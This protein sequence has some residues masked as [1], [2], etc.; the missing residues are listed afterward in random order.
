MMRS[1]I[2]AKR[3]AVVFVCLI[4]SACGSPAK[5]KN[6]IIEATPI[7]TQSVVIPTPAPLSCTATASSAV[8]SVFGDASGN[9]LPNL[10]SPPV[11]VTVAS[12]RAG[13]PVT[14]LIVRIET[15]SSDFRVEPDSNVSA[16]QIV[17]RP[18]KKGNH[19]A[20]I[21][22]ATADNLSE[23]AKCSF[24]VELR[25][26][27]PPDLRVMIAANGAGPSITL[28][29][30]QGAVINWAAANATACLLTRDGV[31]LPNQPIVGVLSGE[32]QVGPFAN[33]GT[34]PLSTVYGIECQGPAGTG[35]LQRA[36]VGVTVNPLPR[37]ELDIVGAGASKTI[38]QGESVDLVWSSV[39][40]TN[41]CLLS[42]GI[43]SEFVPASGQMRMENIPSSVQYAIYCRDNFRGL[44]SD[45][46]NVAAI[47]PRV[48]IT[49][50][51]IGGSYSQ[52]IRE[53]FTIGWT[54]VDVT[55]CSVSPLNDNRIVG[56]VLV[57]AMG[58][59]RTTIYMV[60]C[61]SYFG[62]VISSVTVNYLGDWYQTSK[63]D[64]GNQ[65]DCNNFCGTFG[66]ANVNSPDGSRCAS[67]ELI[68]PSALGKIN[69]SKGCGDYS[70]NTAHGAPNGRS[71]GFAANAYCW[72]TGQKTNKNNSD[73]VMGCFC[74]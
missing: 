54:G 48:V 22:V 2:N 34:I 37:A 33:A 68:P 26:T 51:G 15:S 63:S 23:V 65:K 36:S 40:A 14:A 30:G 52:G 20:T 71:E 47:N 66:K 9:L 41:G 74:R 43:T 5:K 60:T 58:F 39:Y 21:S 24:Q 7:P 10:S 16:G 70:C 42:N 61:Q 50:N 57:P 55:S 29:E 73:D 13:A 62:S 44:A 25:V 49:A 56:S 67:G 45:T 38:R 32:F 17:M 3:F 18:Y 35:L 72:G 59:D 6:A 19:S 11:Q 8:L 69:F 28:S 1:L 64:F 53:S 31:A 27:S 4:L 46:V 12:L